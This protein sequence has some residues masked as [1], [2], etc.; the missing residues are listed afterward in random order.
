MII[1]VIL[2][3]EKNKEPRTA[4]HWSVEGGVTFLGA[5]ELDADEVKLNAKTESVEDLTNK[6][7]GKTA[8][9]VASFGFPEVTIQPPTPAKELEVDENDDSNKDSQ[10]ESVSELQ[11]NQSTFVSTLQAMKFVFT[12]YYIFLRIH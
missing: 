2:E 6:E 12:Y 8:V 11:N 9:T 5:K 4:V 3:K 10:A 7:E 1:F